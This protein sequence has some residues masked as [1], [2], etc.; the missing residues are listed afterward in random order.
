[1]T[2]ADH[3]TMASV[4][5]V[6]FRRLA[7]LIYN[8]VRCA[9]DFARPKQPE[10]DETQLKDLGLQLAAAK[11]K[12][13]VLTAELDRQISTQA[14]DEEK[15]EPVTTSKD[16]EQPFPFLKLPP[17]LRDV[18]YGHCLKVG[19]VFF[20]WKV[21][22]SND[23]RFRYLYGHPEMLPTKPAVQLLRVS[24]QVGNEALEY[25]MRNNT[26]YA[27]PKDASM[28]IP[29]ATL[30]WVRD[31]P[32][33]QLPITR[34]SVAC[35]IRT[36]DMNEYFEDE[37][38]WI[39]GNWVRDRGHTEDEKRAQMHACLIDVLF[40]RHWDEFI[41]DIQETNTSYL[42]VNLQNCMCPCHCDSLGADVAYNLGRWPERELENIPD[43][44]RFLGLLDSDYRA[45]VRE[46]FLEGLPHG[47]KRPHITFAGAFVGTEGFVDSSVWQGP[48]ELGEEPTGSDKEG[49]GRKDA[50]DL[51]GV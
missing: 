45:G 21:V 30:K 44:I 39:H 4:Q 8:I 6:C 12:V 5:C 46:E 33:D 43:E 42:E 27:M 36:F 41:S 13:S 9:P 15:K 14:Q 29:F 17:E 23:L 2:V 19:K 3:E 26:L 10:M 24:R 18:I 34:I 16:D 7:L 49:S 51:D 35:D 25:I 40:D 1:M 32:A 28:P 20:D 22:P 31:G 47:C 11:E 37:L 38:D 50:E 48:E